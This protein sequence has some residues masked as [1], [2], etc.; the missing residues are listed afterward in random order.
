M[1]N[2]FEQMRRLSFAMGGRVLI[3]N[4]LDFSMMRISA[5]KVH[6]A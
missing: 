5:S 6:S 2:L 1:R 4:Q 3:R